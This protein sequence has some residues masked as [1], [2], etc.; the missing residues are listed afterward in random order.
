MDSGNSG[1]TE[2]FANRYWPR[3]V[4]ARTRAAGAFALARVLRSLLFGVGTADLLSYGGAALVMALAVLFACGLP[5]WRAARVDPM[6][7]LRN[8]G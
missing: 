4:P 2:T 7:A 8:D 1:S 6:V 3:Q 5:A